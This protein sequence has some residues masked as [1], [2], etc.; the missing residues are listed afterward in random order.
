[1]KF[2]TCGVTAEGDKEMSRVLTEYAKWNKRQMREI[3]VAKAYFISLG[4]TNTTKKANPETIEQK[5]KASS[6][7]YSGVPL[8]AILVNYELGKKGKK[9]LTGARMVAAIQKFDKK[10]ASKVKAVSSAWLPAIKAL[11]FWNKKGDVTFTKKFAPKKAQGLRQFGK[12]KGYATIINQTG[13]CIVTIANMF[14]QG[15]QN[16][17][18][19]QGVLE[20]GLMKAVKKEIASM[21][22]YIN[23]KYAEKFQKMKQGRI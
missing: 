20:D 6:T 5:L 4:A 10:E 11:D 22:S 12:E 23:R 17:R 7:K 9:G 14:G 18:T 1:M 16:S 13:K 21:I 15:K 2:V 3:G 8:D 19:V